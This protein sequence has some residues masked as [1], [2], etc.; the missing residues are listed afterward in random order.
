MDKEKDV[1]I[2]DLVLIK[3]RKTQSPEPIVEKVNLPEETY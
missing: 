1:G 3:L 2:V